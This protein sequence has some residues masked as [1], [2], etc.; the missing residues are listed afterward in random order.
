MVGNLKNV[1]ET[2]TDNVNEVNGIRK[3]QRT[4]NFVYVII[5]LYIY[6]FFTMFRQPYMPFFPI[7]YSFLKE[8]TLTITHDYC[9]KLMRH[10]E[11]HK[12]AFSVLNKTKAYHPQQL[13]KIN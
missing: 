12:L 6:D 13:F 3:K 5:L 4:D 10:F 9:L 7:L 2:A 8:K 1:K 11:C